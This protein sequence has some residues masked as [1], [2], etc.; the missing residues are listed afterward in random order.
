VDIGNR[1]RVATT[2]G[3]VHLVPRSA[4]P[5][6][7]PP[8]EGSA[9]L[10]RFHLLSE[11]EHSRAAQ[12]A[13]SELS[14][15]VAGDRASPPEGD[16]P[17][18]AQLTDLARL[19]QQET[20]AGR[21]TLSFEPFAGAFREHE[22]L[23][24]KLPPLGP[25]ARS[26]AESSFISVRLLDQRGAPV[27]QRPLRIELPDGSVHASVTDADGF[28]RVRGF[29]KDGT[30]KVT[31]LD[32]D[33]LDL[34]TKIATA[35]RRIIPVDENGI[36]AEDAAEE[37]DAKK[38]ETA[39]Q[40][41]D[42]GDTA[43]A[44]AGGEE[45]KEEVG[46]LFVELFDKRGRTR[47]TERTF[48]ITGPQAFE[49]KTD[50]QGRLLRE[51]VPVGDYSL[52]LALDFF[53]DSPDATVDIVDAP[54]VVLAP[55]TSEPQV[56]MIGAVPRS[57]LA[58]LRTFF[59]TNKTFLLPTALPA[60]R[61]LRALYED[62]APCQLLVVGHAD[63]RG[64][65]P[66]N[67]KLSLERAEATVAFLKDDVDG[68]FKFYS[69]PDAKKQWGKTEDHLMISALPDYVDK[70][71]KEDEVTFFQR[72]RNLKKV[73]GKPGEE[74]RRALIAEYMSLDAASLKDFAGKIEVTA[75]GCGENFP[76]DDSG[77]QLDAAPA[78]E[79]RDRIDRRVEL[80]FFD[81]E[82]GITPK[83]PGKNSPPGSPEYPLWRKRV[84][85]VVELRPG[86]AGG[87][88]VDF[89]E[90]SDAHFRT[91]SAVVL[92][93]G[94]NPDQKGKHAAL[95]S[96]GLIAT[97]LRFNE[98]HAGRSVFVA[99]H[100][101]TA[102]G[103][104]LN[105]EL[106]TLRAKVALALLEGDRGAFSS[107]AQQ[108]HKNADIN[109]ILSWV[110]QAFEDLT[111]DCKPSA[112]GDYVND[113]TVRKFQ[114]DFNR[115]RVAL[116]SPAADLVVDGSVKEVTWGAFFDC[117]EFA[118]QQEL[119]ENAAGLASLRA[120]LKFTDPQRKAL[121]FGEHFPIEELGVDEFRS[122]SNRR[123][124]IHLFQ[125][126]EEP[127]L[128]DAEADASTSELYLPGRFERLPVEPL[129]SAKPWRATWDS[130]NTSMLETR[131]MQVNAPG[132][133]PGVPVLFTILA[134]G[135]GPAG[136]VTAVSLDG[137]ASATFAAWDEMEGIE[138]LGDDPVLP[139][140]DFVFVLEGGGRR[141]V[142]VL[143]VRYE[144]QAL[145]RLVLRL[146][147]GDQPLPNE[148]F[149]LATRWGR[150]KGTTDDQAVLDVKGLPPGGASVVVRGNTLAHF[151]VI[152]LGSD[153]D[154][155]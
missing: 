118:L 68:W 4:A 80:Y 73:D 112:I 24:I 40:L 89:I 150:I 78:D 117:Y 26:D 132:L 134:V 152:D 51:N 120:Q 1:W 148:P 9:D 69:D 63:T 129:I 116:G 123:V 103:D 145:F 87:P 29:T 35:A 33:E 127:D 133:P 140:I 136:V 13:L 153:L 14:A 99:G 131:T 113:V 20:D 34:K 52:S 17:S 147:S 75:H 60:I 143:P 95:T 71:K 121:G 93:E 56:R 72:T 83:P 22:L 54:L 47:H 139:A 76:L 149:L 59:N 37:S 57:V 151:G 101:D 106:S 122:Q 12:Q 19:L 110:S 115:N 15:S 65:K 77:E 8:V 96:V 6:P 137:A 28:G 108:R 36:V 50:A 18:P 94:E 97:V 3:W 64:G 42:A 32:I 86:D 45:V 49:G 138:F 102:A 146:P 155:A 62:N 43:A 109:Q 92:P 141:I 10:A 154:G 61:K 39:Q 31:F 23:D 119:G 66:F 85:Q 55:T 41:A 104:E 11:L 114:K 21:L 105:D 58:Q 79:K 74:T 142:P 144:D 48:Q 125:Q 38:L 46:K 111:F 25:A 126:G 2:F 67:D 53:L 100:T 128:A 70:P 91:D 44:L 7:A 81:N 98:E 5:L 107:L 88:K 135:K 124:E 27:I 30:A 82:F 90:I 16:T 130:P 84:E